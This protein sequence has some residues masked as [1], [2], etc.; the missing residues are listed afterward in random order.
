M[1]EM[2]KDIK[3]YEGI[4]QVSNLGRVKNIL[5]NRIKTLT[6]NNY[7][8]Y[9]HV[10][11]GYKDKVKN[12]YI[13]RLVAEAFIDNPNQY[14]IVNHKDFNKANNTF[15]NL[16]WC[17]QKYNVNY[18]WISGRMPAPPP[19]VPYKVKRSDGIIFNSIK[20]AGASMGINSCII[21]NQLKGRQKTIKGYTFEYCN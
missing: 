4:Y 1:N 11:L 6:K 9:Y 20:E 2:W 12:F 15:E 10:R 7:N 19:Q 17:N 8:G 18:T 5:R 14:N 3:G 21:C 16:E 13:H